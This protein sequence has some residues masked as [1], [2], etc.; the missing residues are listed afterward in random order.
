MSKFKSRKHKRFVSM[1]KRRA[2]GPKKDERLLSFRRGWRKI[3][4]MR[5]RLPELMRGEIGWFEGVR[6][7]HSPAL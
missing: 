4:T 3:R 7:I 5:G 2:F 6:V 1:R